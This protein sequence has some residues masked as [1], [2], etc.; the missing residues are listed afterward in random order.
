MLLSYLSSSVNSTQIRFSNQPVLSNDGKMSCKGNLWW[1]PYISYDRAN[2]LQV[3]R[4][5]QC[6]MSCLF[7]W[8]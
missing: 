3:R 7:N 2:I 4:S 5:T 8:P 6:E 1:G